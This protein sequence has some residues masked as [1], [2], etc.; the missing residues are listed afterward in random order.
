MGS[1]NVFVCLKLKALSKSDCAG[2]SQSCRGWLDFGQVTRHPRRPGR[3][4]I[5]QRAMIC[6]PWAKFKQS[7]RGEQAR[8][9]S[10]EAA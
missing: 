3:S 4:V 7:T 10:A 9:T 8:T 2:R 6:S 1:G 5:E